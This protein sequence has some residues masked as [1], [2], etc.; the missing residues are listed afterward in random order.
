[1]VPHG[2][3]P[4]QQTRMFIDVGRLRVQSTRV[5]NGRRHQPYSRRAA[6][7]CEAC[8]TD[9]D[10][11]GGQ[12]A[13]T[14]N[15]RFRT[16]HP[17]ISRRCT[18]NQGLGL[19]DYPPEVWLH[20]PLAGDFSGW[21]PNPWPVGR[22]TGSSTLSDRYAHFT[23]RPRTSMLPRRRYARDRQSTRW[24]RTRGNVD[25]RRKS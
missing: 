1:L 23:A 13:K 9:A 2:A 16:P 5:I 8:I 3:L 4:S 19:A 18:A 6:K 11:H 17:D 7:S 22:Y 25:K 15:A 21:L 10:K 20:P 12:L 24:A 14:F